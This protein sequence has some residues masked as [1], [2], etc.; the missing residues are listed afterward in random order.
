MSAVQ[1]KL[2]NSHSLPPPPTLRS[3]VLNK[4]FMLPS[5][6]VIFRCSSGQFALEMRLRASQHGIFDVHCQ[7]SVK[8]RAEV[9][10]CCPFRAS[11]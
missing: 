2:Q 6:S 9:P 7:L 3:S 10:H 1:L 8:R 5:V 11:N 4:L